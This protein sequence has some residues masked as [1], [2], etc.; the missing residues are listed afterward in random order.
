M[1]LCQCIRLVFFA[2]IE[3]DSKNAAASC[4]SN[5]ERS[6]PPRIFSINAIM[7]PPREELR[8]DYLDALDLLAELQ[9]AGPHAPARRRSIGRRGSGR[10]GWRRHHRGGLVAHRGAAALVIAST[11]AWPRAASHQIVVG[12]RLGR[13]SRLC[14][15]DPASL[16]AAH[17]VCAP[18]GGPGFRAK[19]ATSRKW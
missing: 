7:P 14:Q 8:Q 5:A 13:S 19:R 3:S 4:T 1:K 11:S 12:A 16:H 6:L 15:P 18:V 17:S 10:R 2:S 9:E